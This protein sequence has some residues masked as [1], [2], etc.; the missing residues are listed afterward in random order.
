MLDLARAYITVLHYLES[1]PFGSVDLDNPYWFTE[2]TGDDE[3]SWRDVA[4]LIGE[5]LHKAGLISDPNPRTLPPDTYGD[6]FGDFTEGVVGTNSRSR[7]VRLREL[8]WKPVEKDWK[9][10]FVQD[11]L[12]VILSERKDWKTFSGYAGPVAS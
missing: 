12:P 9:E 6:I 11:E 2:T 5:S 4:S 3:T 1:K 7:A 8:G 10:S